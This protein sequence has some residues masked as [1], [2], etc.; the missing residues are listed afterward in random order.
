MKKHKHVAAPPKA[1]PGPKPDTL[2]I[3][4]DWRDVVKKSLQ[5]KKPATGWPKLK[6]YLPTTKTTILTVRGATGADTS[7]F[8]GLDIKPMEAGKES[9][10]IKIAALVLAET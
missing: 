6:W 3:E 8:F 9:V 5:K 2:K 1:T 7:N 4:G 10:R